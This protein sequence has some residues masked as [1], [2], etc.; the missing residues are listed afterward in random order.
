MR[1]KRT[2][3]DGLRADNERL[4]GELVEV[5]EAVD[6]LEDIIVA[7]VEDDALVI[8]KHYASIDYS[9]IWESLVLKARA[10]LKG[11]VNE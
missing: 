5:C 4:R 1:D 3:E 11:G 9:D 6:N 10:V 7:I 8:E 2:I